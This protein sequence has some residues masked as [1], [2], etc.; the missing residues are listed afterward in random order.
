MDGFT[1][2]AMLLGVVADAGADHTGVQW[3]LPFP[4]ALERA[5]SEQRLLLIKP[6]AF[7][8]DKDGGW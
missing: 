6:I 4:K 2:A 3:A 5:Q 7:G 8:T 1:F